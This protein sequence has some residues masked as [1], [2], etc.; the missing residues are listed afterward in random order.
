M[1]HGILRV[2]VNFDLQLANLPRYLLFLAQKAV[3]F[4]ANL[5][6]TR[7][8]EFAALDFLRGPGLGIGCVTFIGHGILALAR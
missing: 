7:R 6:G 8:T 2:E 5:C 3:G 1:R 4:C